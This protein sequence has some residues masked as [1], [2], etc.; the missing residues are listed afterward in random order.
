MQE[1]ALE[2]AAAEG[3]ARR[4]AAATR[5]DDERAA[6]LQELKRLDAD[7][8]A[9]RERLLRCQGAADAAAA[10]AEAA[11]EGAR[12]AEERRDAVR[13]GVCPLSTPAMCIYMLTCLEVAGVDS[14]EPH[15]AY[16]R[17]RTNKRQPRV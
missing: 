2:A 15:A 17:V 14:G 3:E 8:A 7:T 6:V 10:E 11:A 4:R 1:A 12:E 13:A 9:A 16:E 5:A